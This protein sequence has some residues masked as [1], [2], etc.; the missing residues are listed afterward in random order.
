MT[1][2]AVSFSRPL[3]RGRF[4]VVYWDL[5]WRPHYTLSRRNLSGLRRC[6]QLGHT[7]WK[8]Q[9]MEMNNDREENER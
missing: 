3:R 1:P 2:S 4:L 7:T 9:D 5:D 6:R 8:N